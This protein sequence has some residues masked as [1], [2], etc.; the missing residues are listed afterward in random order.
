[1]GYARGVPFLVCGQSQSW[2]QWGWCVGSGRRL[3]GFGVGLLM[4]QLKD[5]GQPTAFLSLHFLKPKVRM[6][7]ACI[8]W[9]LSIVREMLS[10]NHL[11]SPMDVFLEISHSPPH[12]ESNV[13]NWHL[14][15]TAVLW[16]FG[17]C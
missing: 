6:M 3:S 5:S 2:E 14:L 4:Y 12:T 11:V 16:G 15:L 8:S 13:K 7:A 1:M 17:A 9:V 10:V